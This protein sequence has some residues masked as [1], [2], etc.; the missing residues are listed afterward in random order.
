M[1]IRFKEIT[2]ALKH[3]KTITAKR[4]GSNFKISAMKTAYTAGYLSERDCY[5]AAKFFQM[6]GEELNHAKPQE[7]EEK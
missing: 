3:A 7:R 5:E 4:L 1:S 2:L 6:L